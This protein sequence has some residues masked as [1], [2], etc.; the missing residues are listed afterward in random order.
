M[1]RYPLWLISALA[2]FLASCS[3]PSLVCTSPICPVAHWPLNEAPGATAV[4]D[5]VTNPLFNTG[6]PKPGPVVAW[7]GFSGP[8]AV[9]GQSGGA[10]YFPGNGATWVEV[11]STPDL[12]LSYGS[13]YLEAHVAP[14][15][16][17]ANAYYP[18]LDKWDLA[19]ANGYTL[20]LEGVGP[21]QVRVAF[22]LGGG[23]FTSTPFSAS[24][25]PPSAGTWTKVAVKVDGTSGA[26]YVNGNLAG[27]FSA[28]SGSTTNTLPLWIGA[29]HTAPTG[30]NH[31][32]IALDE[33]RVGKLNP[34]FSTP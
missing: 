32:E 9:S 5:L 34:V 20:Y 31:C 33:L 18:I 21:G 26:F 1:V 11:P 24:F 22:R 25:Q 6:T 27:T 30:L 16:C 15:Q 23:T 12:N 14:V 8:S 19:S 7:P 17:G 13:L 28:P 29:L 2:L 3:G 4:Q 10:F